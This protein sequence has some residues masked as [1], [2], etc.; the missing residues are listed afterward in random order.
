MEIYDLGFPRKEG[1]RI[2]AHESLGKRISVRVKEAIESSS[3]DSVFDMADMYDMDKTA[4][5]ALKSILAEKAAEY[6]IRAM[7]EAKKRKIKLGAAAIIL[8]AKRK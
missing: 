1:Y 8:A 5:A 4:G 6:T 3:F 2:G 7:E